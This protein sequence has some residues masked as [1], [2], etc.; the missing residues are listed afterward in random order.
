MIVAAE[1]WRRRL[2]AVFPS[3][4]A[5]FCEHVECRDTRYLLP[6]HEEMAV[7]LA[8]AW[9]PLADIRWTREVGDCDEFSLIVMARVREALL[10]RAAAGEIPQ[11]KK[12]PWAI[13][14]AAGRDPGGEEHAFN[15]F[16][17]DRGVWVFDRGRIE[18]PA[19]YEPL[20][21]RF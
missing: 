6:P 3:L 17:T 5:F 13:G 7:V 2:K 20:S 15:V 1:D 18:D 10:R 9:G 11:Q 12:A 21:A 8:A 4:K 14:D 19:G 16:G